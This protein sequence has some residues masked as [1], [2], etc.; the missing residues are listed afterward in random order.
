MHPDH[1]QRQPQAARVLL[2]VLFGTMSF[3]L[4]V[5]YYLDGEHELVIS[6]AWMLTVVVVVG[7][8]VEFFSSIE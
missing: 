5:L 3:A 1:T 8:I 2:Y 4:M 7:V 6:V